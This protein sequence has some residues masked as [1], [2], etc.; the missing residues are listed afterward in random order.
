ME[1]KEDGIFVSNV[2]LESIHKSL[3]E[4]CSKCEAKNYEMCFK[5]K[6]DEVIDDL[7]FIVSFAGEENE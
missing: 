2:F 3:V 1:K 7:C 5:C 4:H 6:I